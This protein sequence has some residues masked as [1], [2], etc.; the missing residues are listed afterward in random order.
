MVKTIYVDILFIINFIINYLILFTCAHIHTIHLRRFRI[1]LSAAFAALYGVLAFFPELSF[2]T[3]FVIKLSLSFVIILIAFG[4]HE[5]LRNTLSFLTVSLA[6]AGFVF[7]AS[8]LDPSGTFEIENGIYYIHLSLP[9][10]LISTL[11]CYAVLSLIFYRKGKEEMK[12]VCDVEIVNCGN[13]IKLRALRDTGNSLRAPKTN[14]P[15]LIC[16]YPSV[17]ELFPEEA[18]AVLDSERG[19][20]YPLLLDKLSE[21]GKFGLVPYKSLGVSFSLLLSFR[22]DK[23]LR[24]GNPVHGALIALS[25]SKISD[26]GAYTAII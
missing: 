8:Q 26:G 14:A 25:D 23:I 9:T 24:N 2:L 12:E 10:L 3:S 4:K 11:I 15:V 22:P 21:Y 6:L 5:L 18:K 19:E 7:A 1:V 16:D 13:S 17:R 20:N